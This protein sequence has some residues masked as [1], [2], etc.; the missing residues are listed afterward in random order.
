MP[1]PLGM[2][3]YITITEEEGDTTVLFE[4]FPSPVDEGELPVT[5]AST[6]TLTFYKAGAEEVRQLMLQNPVYYS[7]LMGYEDLEG[8]GLVNDVLKCA[9]AEAAS[10]QM[11]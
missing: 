2:R 9:P 3:A 11:P 5:I 1:N 6:R 10:S 8:F 4:Q 7:E